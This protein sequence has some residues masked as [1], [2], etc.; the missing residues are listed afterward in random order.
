[1]TE[2]TPTDDQRPDVAHDSRSHHHGA[3]GHPAIERLHAELAAAR[4]GIGH[5]GTM[6]PAH[7]DRVVAAIRSELPDAASRAAHQV[8]GA[9]T[10]A[11]I[12]HFE[13]IDPARPVPSRASV[14]LWDAILTDVVEAISAVC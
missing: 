14:R 8:G 6:T 4:R 10:M 5:T 12:R 11:E 7:R 2:S 1:M 9:A 13:G 3:D